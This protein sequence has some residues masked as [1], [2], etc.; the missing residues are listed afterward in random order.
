MNIKVR[1]LSAILGFLDTHG[2]KPKHPQRKMGH[3]WCT[4]CS[5]QPS[6]KNEGPERYKCLNKV[7][8]KKHKYINISK[9]LLFLTC[10]STLIKNEHIS[11]LIYIFKI[12]CLCAMNIKNFNK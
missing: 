6:E 2:C 5:V 7:L 9:Y 11:T 3:K 4:W 10:W 1:A 8:N 12:S